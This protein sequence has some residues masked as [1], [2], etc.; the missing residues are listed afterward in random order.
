MGQQPGAR[1]AAPF[2]DAMIPCGVGGVYDNVV[3]QG[4]E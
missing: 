4:T 3:G 1:Q 2:Y